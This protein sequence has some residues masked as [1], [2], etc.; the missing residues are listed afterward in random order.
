MD[1][2]I[3]WASTDILKANIF[4]LTE[5]ESLDVL[6]KMLNRGAIEY[7]AISIDEIYPE[8]D[9]AIGAT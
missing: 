4:S 7:I 5:L 6:N 8:I 3:G 1:S 2:R 9:T